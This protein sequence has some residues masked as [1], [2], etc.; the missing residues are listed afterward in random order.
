MTAHRSTLF[1]NDALLA[2]G[3]MNGRLRDN[4]K[5]STPNSEK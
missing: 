3:Y 5:R 2:P 1:I 4:R